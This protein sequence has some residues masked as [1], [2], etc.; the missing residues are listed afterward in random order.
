MKKLFSSLLLIAAVMPFHGQAE[1]PGGTL[2]GYLAKQ[3]F[4]GVK[5]GIVIDRARQMLY[6]NPSGHGSSVSQSLV[7]LLSSRGFARIPLHLNAKN[8][9]DVEG[10]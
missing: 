9:F 2:L 7:S 6:V 5:F 8:H 3:G 1:E 4:A 10:K